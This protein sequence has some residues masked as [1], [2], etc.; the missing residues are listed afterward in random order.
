MEITEK[1]RLD[2]GRPASLNVN[3]PKDPRKDSCPTCQALNE[4]LTIVSLRTY[5]LEVG[6]PTHRNKRHVKLGGF[7]WSFPYKMCFFSCFFMVFQLSK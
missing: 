4:V 6:K 5:F 2:I 1:S 3:F 7:I